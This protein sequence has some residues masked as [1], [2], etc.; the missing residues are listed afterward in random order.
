M[1]AI[2]PF[3]AEHSTFILYILTPYVSLQLPLSIAERSF[4]NYSNSSTNL[5]VGVS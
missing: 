3:M 1:N 5:T 2:V 4:C